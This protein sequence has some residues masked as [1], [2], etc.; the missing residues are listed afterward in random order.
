MIASKLFS[1][2][3]LKPGAFLLFEK[4]TFISAGYSCSLH[5]STIDFKFEPR[6]DIK[7]PMGC[8]IIKI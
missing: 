5:A 8:L 6:P 2:A 4:T 1:F 3:K 7:I